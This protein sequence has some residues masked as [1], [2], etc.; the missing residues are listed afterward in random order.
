MQASEIQRGAVPQSGVR[1][2]DFKASSVRDLMAAVG[3]GDHSEAWM[4]LPIPALEKVEQMPADDSRAED[5][6][7]EVGAIR[8]R[9]RRKG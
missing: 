9:G 4:R 8:R 1:G 5:H 2:S 6:E 3:E 7:V